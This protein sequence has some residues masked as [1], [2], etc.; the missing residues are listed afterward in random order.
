MGR[1]GGVR[2][3]RTAQSTAR[4]SARCAQG[5]T[6]PALPCQRQNRLGARRRTGGAQ[7]DQARL[8]VQPGG[9]DARKVVVDCDGCAVYLHE[10][11]LVQ[12]DQPAQRRAQLLDLLPA[13]HASA[14][15]A[16]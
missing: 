12:V 3:G 9:P 1:A 8:H 13:A 6:R 10:L 5:S 11:G 7:A 2:A 14:P 16:L 15:G 4:S